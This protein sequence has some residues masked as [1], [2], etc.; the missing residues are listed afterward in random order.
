MTMQFIIPV[1]A[2]FSAPVQIGP[3][4]HPVQWYWVFTGGKELPVR[5]A[6]PS[7]PSSNVVI[8]E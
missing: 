3:G 7:S 6:D 5:E 8:K 4:A 1:G 2:T